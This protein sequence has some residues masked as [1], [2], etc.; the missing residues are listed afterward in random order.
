MN[1]KVPC[2]FCTG[3][4]HTR[5][6]A[7]MGQCWACERKPPPGPRLIVGEER[8]QLLRD[9]SAW[10]YAN[11]DPVRRA[12]GAG[13]VPDARWHAILYPEEQS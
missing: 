5:T 7:R 12:N 8:A 4:T 9:F 1:R 6:L 2:P 10:L 3:M 13:V 11:P